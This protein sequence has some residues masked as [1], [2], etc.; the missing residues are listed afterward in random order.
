M[1]YNQ[2]EEY[3]GYQT[4]DLAITFT[5]LLSIVDL[6]C[7]AN[8]YCTAKKLSHTQTHTHIHTRTHT[9]AYIYSFHYALSQDI[10]FSSVCYTLGPCYLSILYIK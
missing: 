6:Q 7:C 10:V 8:L 1:N 2:D 3:N 4:L 5:I 9:H